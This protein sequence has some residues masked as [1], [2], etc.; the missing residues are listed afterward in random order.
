[1]STLG[2]TG[3][4]VSALNPNLL[5]NSDFLTSAFPAEYGNALAGVFDIGLRSGNRDK[6]EFML[7]MGAFSGLEG[8]AEGPVGQPGSGNSY[9]VA[10]RYG[11]TG[12]ADVLGLNFGTSAVPNY[13]DVSFKLDFANGKAGKFSVFGIGGLSQIDF[14][15]DEVDEMDLF[16]ANDE[17]AFV[18]SGFGVLGVRHNLLLG[19]DA[20]LR[21]VVAGSVS[22]NTFHSDR[23]FQLN[24]AEEFTRPFADVDNTEVRYSVSS[25]YNQKF[26]AR[27]TGRFGV[28]AELFDYDL[29]ADDAE[30]GPD[31]DSDGIPELVR[32]YAFDDQATLLQPFAQAKYRFTESWTLNAGLHA[33]YL[34]LN[35]T[36]ALE[37]RLALNWDFAPN[38][39]LTLGF[40]RHSQTVPIPILLATTTDA[41]SE[42]S[43]PNEALE[44]TRS[45]HVVLGYDNKFAADWRLKAEVYYQ[46]LTNVPVDPYPSSFSILN[47]GADFV[48]PRGKFGLVNEG[49]GEN[50]GLELTVEKFFSRGYYGL[51]TASVYDSRYEGSDR[52][53]RSTA[54]NNSYVLNVLAGKEW[55]V[56]PDQ[57]HAITFD[58]R[59]VTAGGRRFTP[60]DL[61]ASRQAGFQVDQEDQAFSERLDPY[62]RLDVK[63]GFTF[64]S[65]KHGVAHR[66]Y[67]DLQNVTNQE[68]LF[69]RRYNRLTN[70]VNDVNQ[71]GFFPDFMY[72]VQF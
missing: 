16:A 29:R 25:F 33:Q 65:K 60:V 30:M 71:L 9:L 52:V 46:N 22:A 66:F 36:F 37:P 5:R 3:G 50:Y 42:V 6:H 7:Q 26:N 28:L 32:V 12:L 31:T 49:T 69:V 39:R 34:T 13:Q 41:S 63:V 47:T 72:R 64:N 44:F 4:P 67:L 51:L 27:L 23:Y 1:F 2:T 55:R 18:N 56:G 21:T 14:L 57:R 45:N 40:G 70:Q 62:L 19:N 38:Q 35:E 10:G 20:Y 48:F 11:F 8:M 24:T 68:N 43:R 17:D 53:Q 58:T 54:F 59:F 61:E 15:H